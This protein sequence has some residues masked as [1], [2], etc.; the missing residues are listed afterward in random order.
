MGLQVNIT[1]F[2]QLEVNSYA[3]VGNIGGTKEEQFFTIDYYASRNAFLRKL[4]P[5]KQENYKFTP[6]VMDDSLNF[7]KQAYIYV[8]RRTEF[9]GAVDVLEEGQKS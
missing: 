8:K 5:I 6:S 2:N 7:V 1:L 3:R 4:D 9:A